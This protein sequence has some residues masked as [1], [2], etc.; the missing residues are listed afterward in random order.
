MITKKHFI[1]AINILALI[2]FAFANFFDQIFVPLWIIAT[3]LWLVAA[4]VLIFDN[5]V[6]FAV[7]NLTFILHGAGSVFP[8]YK[9][10]IFVLLVIG[11]GLGITLVGLGIRSTNRN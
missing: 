3:I 8:A 1:L 5:K 7:I 6:G 4:I 9:Q 11:Y 10:C 2:L